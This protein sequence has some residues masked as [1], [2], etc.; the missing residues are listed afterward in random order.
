[1]TQFQ[2]VMENIFDKY[3]I[4]EELLKKGF[5]KF[6]I[7]MSNHILIFEENINPNIITNL[8]YNIGYKCDF[9]ENKIELTD[10]E[11]TLMDDAI[12]NGYK[13]I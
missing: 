7:N 13:I 9:I 11:I 4:E 3:K 12:R 2:L 8:I 10:E 5:N 1:M 6:E